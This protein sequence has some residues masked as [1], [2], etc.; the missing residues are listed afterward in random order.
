M[1]ELLVVKSLSDYFFYSKKT[2]I[3]QDIFHVY[4]Q[5][6]TS[7]I[8]VKFLAC[9]K[10]HYSYPDLEHKTNA[11]QFI[12]NIIKEYSDLEL[13]FRMEDEKGIIVRNDL[14]KK[15]DTEL[16]DFVNEKIKFPTFK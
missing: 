5:K 3:A 2:G 14:D 6:K 1:N 11:S 10:Y 4:D 7:Q 12:I 16:R 15:T 9:L 8:C 13:I